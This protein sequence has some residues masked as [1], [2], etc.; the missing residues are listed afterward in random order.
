MPSSIPFGAEGRRSTAVLYTVYDV[1][2][3]ILHSFAIRFI[4]VIIINSLHFSYY[5]NKTSDA[6]SIVG[7]FTQHKSYDNIHVRT[8]YSRIEHIPC[9]IFA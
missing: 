9:W 8:S 4:T 7:V 6:P 3:I 5:T 2:C 1:T